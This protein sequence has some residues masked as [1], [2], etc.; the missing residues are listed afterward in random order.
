MDGHLPK[1]CPPVLPGEGMEIGDGVGSAVD[2]TYKLSFE[3]PIEIEK[4]T[5]ESK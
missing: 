4:V 1:E 2:F 5:Y 3:F